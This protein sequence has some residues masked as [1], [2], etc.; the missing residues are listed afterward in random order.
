MK[1][2]WLCN[3]LLP[4][5]SEQIGE[6]RNNLGGWLSGLS[7]ALV[8]D[9][10]LQLFYMCPSA[11]KKSVEGTADRI[12]YVVFPASNPLEYNS[13]LEAFFTACIQKIQPDII[14]IFGTEFPHTLAM[15]NASEKCGMLDQTVISI[16]GLVSVYADH[17]CD[18]LPEPLLHGFSLRSAVKGNAIL[19]GQNFYYK[20]GEFEIDALRK[21]RN[22][23][24]R[25]AWDKE[26]TLKINPDIHYWFC[27]ETLRSCFYQDQWNWDHCKKHSIFVSQLSYPIKG[28]HMLMQILPQL[29]EEYPDLQISVTGNDVFHPTLQQK[30]REDPYLRYIRKYVARNHLNDHIAFKGDLDDVSMK[31]EYLNANVFVCPSTIENSSNS[32]G[33]AIMLGTPAVVSAVGGIP[34]IMKGIDNALIYPFS[35]Q[36]LMLKYVRGAFSEQIKMER[37]SSEER[38]KARVLYDA[39][40]NNDTLFQI[41]L[42]L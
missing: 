8:Q 19:K 29:M 27:G 10:E 25:T 41:Y 21:C 36:E 37:I 26:E 33:E 28:F 6:R 24:G 1:I 42:K 12:H 31:R 15:V 3:V 11:V 14:H 23:I 34:T 32:I 18:G 30:I 35:D 39:Q 7:D 5:I 2:L 22:V 16:Q 9:S 20:R 13:D 4:K 40:I 38:K 17:Y